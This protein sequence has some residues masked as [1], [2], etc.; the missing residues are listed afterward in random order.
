MRELSRLDEIIFGRLAK[1]P[2]TRS[3]WWKG[4]WIDSIGF[5]NL[6]LQSEGSLRQSGF[7]RGSRIAVFIPNSPLF[8]SIAVA[9]W[10]LGG[11][12][13]PLNARSGINASVQ[14]TEHIDPIGAVLGEGMENLADALKEKGIPS[15]F[16]VP[17]SSLPVF[18]GREAKPENEDIAV[19]FATSGTTGAPKA[20]QVS[21]ANLIDNSL[22]VHQNIEGFES[23]RVLLNVLPN[24]HTLGFTVCGVLPLCWGLPMVAVSSF[25]PLKETLEAIIS[26]QVSIMIAVPTM[27]PFLLGA[28]SKEGLSFPSLKTILTGGGKLDPTFESRIRREMGIICF[29][30][31]GL[32]ECSP[33]VSCNPSEKSRKLGT[34]GPALPGYEVQVCDSDGKA[35]EA[36]GEGVL[37]LKGP[38]VTSGYF[39]APDL[40]SERFHDGWLDTG[41]IVK[42]DEDGFITILDRATD[43]IIVGGFNV[44][45]QEVETAL[46]SHPAVK[47]SAA[48]GIPSAIS[49]E[50]VKGF[51]VTHENADVTQQELVLFAKEHLAHYK[52]PR[53]IDIVK[54][55]PLSSTGKVLKTQLRE[56]GSENLEEWR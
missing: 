46:N 20:V 30:G 4:S 36:G 38:S 54:D 43:L 10:R 53:R 40:T 8:W 24:F 7:T 26:A 16:G 50:V 41:D 22:K 18:K 31:Y 48:V 14:I 29:E 9:A 55:L 52:V 6:V 13:A 49:G 47:M 51:V 39:R 1:D 56:K 28:V 11:A 27:L 42:L 15:V 45:P 33:V 19:I 3:I 12:I 44:Y 25:I 17:E 2:E 5:T 32:T 21:H 34:V 35:L 37:W 23:G